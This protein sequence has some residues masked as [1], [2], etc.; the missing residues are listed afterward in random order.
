MS[1]RS[2]VTVAE[3]ARNTDPILGGKRRSTGLSL[4]ASDVAWSAGRGPEV[5][6]PLASIILAITGRPMGLDDLYGEGL[7]ALRTRL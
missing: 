4:R 7:D 5:A 3:I 2:L 1:P 6:E